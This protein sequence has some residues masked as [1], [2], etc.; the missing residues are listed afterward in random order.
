M[1]QTVLGLALFVTASVCL[2]DAIHGS[3][4]DTTPVGPEYTAQYQAECR[5]DVNPTPDYSDHELAA[6][7]F[8]TTLAIN[9]NSTLEC[10]AR[11]VNVVIPSAPING[12]WTAWTAASV[13]VTPADASG[14]LFIQVRP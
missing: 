10:R 8:D 7:V 13:A 12:N 9:Q 3:W 14:V 2:A 5:I 1:K 11:N 6:P 4:T